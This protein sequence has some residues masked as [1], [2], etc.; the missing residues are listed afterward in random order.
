MNPSHQAPRSRV[1]AWPAVSAIAIL[2]L[3]ACTKDSTTAPLQSDASLGSPRFSQA[4]D[5][6]LR[7]IPDEYIVVFDQ[8]VGD[9]KGRANALLSAHGGRLNATY[10]SALRGFSAHM[11]AQAAAALAD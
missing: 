10:T 4:S 11:S 3:S 2:T 5:N 7:K 9:V 1:F 6:G 8:S